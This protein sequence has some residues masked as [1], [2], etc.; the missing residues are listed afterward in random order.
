ML[1]NFFVVGAQKCGTTALQKYLVKHPEIFLPKQKE[2]KFFVDDK[3]YAKGIAYYENEYFTS[4][5][6]YRAVGEIDPDYMY[7]DQALERIEQHIPIRPAKTKF[8]FLLRNPIDRAFSHYLMTYRRGI[9]RLSFEDAVD[10]EKDRIN[11]GYHEKMHFSYVSRGFYYRQ[12][13]RF[14]DLVDRRQILLLLAEEFKSNK[15]ESLE[16]VQAFIGVSSDY[17]PANLDQQYHVAS[18]PKSMTLLNR[19]NEQGL[20]KKLV[21]LLLPSKKFRQRLRRRIIDLNL[22]TQHELKISDEMRQKLAN[23]YAEENFKLQQLLG[24]DL[25]HWS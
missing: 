13:M 6:N 22:T 18:V 7:F 3:R 24:K 17:L 23:I 12:I 21:R 14:L 10:K 15:K 2:T 20:E 5:R 1:P 25:S 19:L 4:C 8:V 11:G 9:E 16:K